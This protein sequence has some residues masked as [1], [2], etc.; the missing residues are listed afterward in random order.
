M[1]YTVITVSNNMYLLQ[2]LKYFLFFNHFQFQEV[3][4]Q[5]NEVNNLIY[6]YQMLLLIAVAVAVYFNIISVLLHY[7]HI[8][9][10][11]ILYIRSPARV[12]PPSNVNK[13][14]ECTYVET[15]R[16]EIKLNKKKA[17][18]TKQYIN[19]NS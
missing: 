19:Y 4:E 15:K 6:L 13:H 16:N 10:M 9:H 2:F 7:T 17:E 1:I 8:S 11:Y 14:N 3:F 5:K 12:S 18:F